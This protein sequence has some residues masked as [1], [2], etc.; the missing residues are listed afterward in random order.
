VGTDGATRV[1][2]SAGAGLGRFDLFVSALSDTTDGFRENSASDRA[3]ATVTA[4]IDLGEGRR[5]GLTLVASETEAG[6]PGALTREEWTVDP[7]AAPFNRLDFLDDRSGLAAAHFRGPVSRSWSVAAS[8]S[9]R[10]VDR[11]SLVTGRAAREFGGSF[12]E[13]GTSATEA[14]AQAT[15]D[16]AGG[17]H[18]IVAGLEWSDGTVDARSFATPPSSPGDVDAT[19]PAADNRVD[20]ESTALFLQDTWALR[21]RWTVVLGARHDRNRVAYLDRLASGGGSV[22]EEDTTF[23]AGVTWKPTDVTD[24]YA[25]YSEAFLTPTAEQRFAFPGFGSNPDLRP[26]SSE[27]IEV[28]ATFRGSRGFRL[29]AAT[30]SIDT[31]DE[32]LFDPTPVPDNPFGR[33]VNAGRTRRLGLEL[34]AR[35][36]IATGW[37]AFGNVTWLDAEFRDDAMGRSGR[38][39][40]LVPER[41]ALA[42]IDG[43]VADRVRLRLEIVHVGERPLDGDELNQ[44]PVLDPYTVVHARASWRA[45]TRNDAPGR[46]GLSLFAEA[47]NLLDEEYATR[48]IHAFDFSTSRM[49][50]FFVPAPGRTVL[51][52]LEYVF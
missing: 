35:A 41:T 11:E 22:R 8:L 27:T 50:D 1:R 24:I 16:A 32:I 13:A 4:G 17:K 21:T 20:R 9:R 18:R 45:W 48:G 34:S 28:G 6:T 44:R 49:E 15:R 36:R 40:P 25:A 23:R 7:A 31:R 51:T 33:N 42:G 5:A 43:D 19:S 38:G 47:R 12:L 29:E 52:G 39:V 10:E 30:F 26:E 14:V 3:N 37:H 46:D 2:G